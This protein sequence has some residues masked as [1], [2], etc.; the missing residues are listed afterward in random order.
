MQESFPFN[1]KTE[2]TL[3]NSPDIFRAWV[4]GVHYAARKSSGPGNEGVKDKDFR[5]KHNLT[6]GAYIHS[7]LYSKV[8]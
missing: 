5:Q 2:S 3:T 8:V 7:K 4:Y 1:Y 6:I